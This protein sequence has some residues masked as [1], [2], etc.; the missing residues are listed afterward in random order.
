MDHLLESN[1][2]TEILCCSW[3]FCSHPCAG[4][5]YTPKLWPSHLWSSTKYCSVLFLYPN[6][7]TWIQHIL[8]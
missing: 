1:P 3:Y 8:F 7:T 5:P 2:T 4:L 6:P